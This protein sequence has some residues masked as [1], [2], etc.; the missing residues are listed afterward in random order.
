MSILNKLG[1]YR[2]SE[3]NSSVTVEDSVTHWM[4]MPQPPKGE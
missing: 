2:A 4:A 3:V 1:L